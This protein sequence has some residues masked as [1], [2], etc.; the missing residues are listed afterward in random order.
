MM[1]IKFHGP[2]VVL[3]YFIIIL[4]TFTIRVLLSLFYEKNHFYTV[5]NHYKFYFYC[6]LIDFNNQ[7]IM[8]CRF[9]RLSIVVKTVFKNNDEHN[10]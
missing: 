8:L 7:P 5:L 10:Q 4:N 1:T 6:T 9:N 2:C 3:L